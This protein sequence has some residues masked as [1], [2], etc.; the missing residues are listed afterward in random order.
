MKKKTAS[1]KAPAAGK[2]ARQQQAIVKQV[3]KLPAN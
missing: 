3:G 2:A 1:K